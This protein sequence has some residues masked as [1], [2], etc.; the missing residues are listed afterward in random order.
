MLPFL[1]LEVSKKHIGGPDNGASETFSCGFLLIYRLIIL[2]KMYE[3]RVHWE[4]MFSYHY[5]I[6]RISVCGIFSSY[7]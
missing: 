5:P 1:L 6:F 4:L 2:K 7:N 3:R